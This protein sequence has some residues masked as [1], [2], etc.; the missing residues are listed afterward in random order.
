MKKLDFDFISRLKDN[1]G[2]DHES[3]SDAVFQLFHIASH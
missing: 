2:P 3:W 1:D